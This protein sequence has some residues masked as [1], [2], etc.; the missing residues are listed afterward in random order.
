MLETILKE[1][2]S[3]LKKFKS[4]DF[5]E[6][7]HRAEEI[8]GDPDVIEVRKSFADLMD[9]GK[10][11]LETIAFMCLGEIENRYQQGGIGTIRT[12]YKEVIVVCKNHRTPKE[13]GM[14]LFPKNVSLEQIH[15]EKAN[16]I[17]SHYDE[18]IKNGKLMCECGNPGEIDQTL[19][20]LIL[21]EDVDKIAKRRL[22]VEEVNRE[23][24]KQGGKGM[25]SEDVR[26]KFA[27]PVV[28]KYGFSNLYDLLEATKAFTVDLEDIFDA[29]YAK[30]FKGPVERHIPS[31]IMSITYGEKD[32]LSLAEKYVIVKYG[33]RKRYLHDICRMRFVPY[34]NDIGS[35]IRIAGIF[36]KFAAENKIK[37]VKEDDYTGGTE[38]G[39]R[40]IHLD[41]DP[42]NCGLACE[43]Q[44]RNNVMDTMAVLA[45]GQAHRHMRRKR[46]EEISRLV[47][48]SKVSE[49]E[50][51]LIKLILDPQ[52]IRGYRKHIH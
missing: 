48:E 4:Q 3:V 33:D 25:S 51:Y 35:C 6:I 8:T 29:K 31:P 50:V 37:I 34:N 47:R 49:K 45:E 28:E 17:Y 11:S 24:K 12:P 44:I 52:S 26:Q 7:K 42:F 43:V 40:A 5:E 46:T 19:A 13:I 18:K 1:F 10:K 41:I 21:R 39:Y 15:F 14:G 2:E 36:K 9:S 38:T 32:N 23:L 16:L 20:T 27:N 30:M 22:I